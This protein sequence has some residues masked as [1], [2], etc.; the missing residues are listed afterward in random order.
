[1]FYY[2]KVLFPTNAA[3]DLIV[4]KRHGYNPLHHSYQMM[5]NISY[6]IYF[7]NNTLTDF[8]PQKLPIRFR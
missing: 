5:D 8:V 1:M 7:F 3:S 2:I 6:Y 4:H